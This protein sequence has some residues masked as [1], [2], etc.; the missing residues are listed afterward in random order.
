MALKILNIL[1]CYNS[2]DIIPYVLEYNQ[3]EGIDSFV[4]D[5]YSDDGSWEYLRCN[6]IPCKRMDTGG[7]FLHTKIQASKLPVIQE[8]KPDWVLRGASDHFI[9]TPEPLRATIEQADKDGY[10]AISMPI[11]RMCNTGEDAH[12]DPRKAYFY[13]FIVKNMISIHKTSGFNSYNCEQINMADTKSKFLP[14]ALLLDYGNTRPAEKRE[15]EY[16]RMQLAW[17]RGEPRGHGIHYAPA[18]EKG[19]KWEKDS[20]LDIRKSEYWQTLC[21]RFRDI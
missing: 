14:G 3:K 1:A 11:G 20:L 4:L 2:L 13:Y 17:E 9:L 15:E 10:N 5:N 16:K 21:N 8:L 19:W 6:N 12:G 7:A 18:S